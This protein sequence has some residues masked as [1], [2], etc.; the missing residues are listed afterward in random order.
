MEILDGRNVKM[1]EKCSAQILCGQNVIG[2]KFDFCANV[3]EIVKP[4]ENLVGFLQKLT[5]DQV[6][7]TVLQIPKSLQSTNRFLETSDLW[8]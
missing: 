6:L 1:G 3:T 4:W 5:L 7:K 2:Q 8:C